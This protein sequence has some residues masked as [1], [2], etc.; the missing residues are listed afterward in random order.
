MNARFPS[1]WPKIWPYRWPLWALKRHIAFLRGNLRAM[2]LSPREWST[3][4]GKK[5]MSYTSDIGNLETSWRVG[6][7]QTRTWESL[8]DQH[9]KNFLSDEYPS[10]SFLQIWF[11]NIVHLG[12]E[13]QSRQYQYR[14]NGSSVEI[15]TGRVTNRSSNYTT[16][17]LV[18]PS[19]N[20]PTNNILISSV[21]S[22]RLAWDPNSNI[23]IPKFCPSDYK[24]KHHNKTLLKRLP[25]LL[26]EAAGW[27]AGWAAGGVVDSFCDTELGLKLLFDMVE[28][29]GRSLVE[30]CSWM[31][32]I[33]SCFNFHI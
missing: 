7:S 20:I 26:L 8:S 17:I 33:A 32:S 5:A 4:A 2:S 6:V 15:Q 30:Q 9:A 29:P 25:D 1:S 14:M 12:I 10:E 23:I 18:S 3:R 19:C 16:Y 13:S 21:A 27:L 31:Q 22:R 24:M 28:W 11:R